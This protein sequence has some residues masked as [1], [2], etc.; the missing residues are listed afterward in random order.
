[1]RLRGEM[2]VGSSS[3]SLIN[4]V[5]NK[6]ITITTISSFSSSSI[7]TRPAVQPIN[8]SAVLSLLL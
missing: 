1:M 3:T 6:L 7:R 8:Y 5:V 2:W 4:P